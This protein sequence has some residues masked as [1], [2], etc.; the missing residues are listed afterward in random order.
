MKITTPLREEEEEYFILFFDRKKKNFH[1][2]KKNIFFDRK[3]NKI[4]PRIEEKKSLQLIT[5][6]SFREEEEIIFG[7]PTP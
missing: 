7:E 5:G 3:K 6:T 2:E 1:K 4:F